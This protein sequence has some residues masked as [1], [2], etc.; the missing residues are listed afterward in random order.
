MAAKDIFLTLLINLIWG[1]NVIVAKYGVGQ[2]P[3]I[4]F[5]F[6]RFAIVAAILL[7]VLRIHRGQMHAIIFVAI[8]TGCI[9]FTLTYKGLAMAADVS[10]V[11]IAMQLG[12]PFA[13][14]LSMV[15][16]G[17]KIRLW[18]WLGLLMAFGGIML[19]SFDPH[20]FAYR[21][22]LFLVVL[23]SLF[24]ASGLLVAKKLK[25]VGVF[26]LQSWIAMISWPLLL[27]MSLVTEPG[28]FAVLQQADL[29]VWGAVLYTALAASV[30]A[31]SAMYYLIQRYD[32]SLVMPTFLL[33][34][35]FAVIFGVTMLD[36]QLTMRMM[37]GGSCTLLGVLLILMR[38]VRKPGTAT[39]P[40]AT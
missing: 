10:S 27:G 3:P 6:L 28:Q 4:L 17:E 35:V 25:G 34:T 32:L 37:V 5:T 14:V 30:L 40:A 19:I 12:I 23:G 36:D 13:T 9:H 7:P 11:A 15:F 39:P 33:A 2:I 26:E 8:T 24:G 31:H 1:F 22:A 20:V 18:R 21:N 29:L 38:Q 16:L